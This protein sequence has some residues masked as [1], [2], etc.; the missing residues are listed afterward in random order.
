M[1]AVPSIEPMKPIREP[2]S[3]HCGPNCAFLLSTPN[4]L[5]VVEGDR[6]SVL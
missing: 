5:H 2:G 3:R 1:V 4:D 6:L